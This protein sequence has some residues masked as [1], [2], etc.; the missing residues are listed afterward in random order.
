MAKKTEKSFKT[1][2][3]SVSK[4]THENAHDLAFRA[5]A[6]SFGKIDLD[7]VDFFLSMMKYKAEIDLRLEAFYNGYNLSPGRFQIL[8]FLRCAADFS[9]SPSDLA[10]KTGVSRATMTQFLDVLE[11]AD[12]VSRKAFP[13]DRRATLIQITPAGLKILNQ[14]ILPVYF[15]RCGLLS[16]RCSKTEMKQFTE[17]YRKISKNLAEIE[18][19]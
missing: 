13:G 15:K 11:K 3:I 1:P 5:L 19:K 2:S 14:E 17:M 7:K 4:M 18:E 6:K 8:M 12:Y 16:G 10:D 9:L